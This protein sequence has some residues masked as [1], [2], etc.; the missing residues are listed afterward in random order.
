MP[1]QYV[2]GG[3]AQHQFDWETFDKQSVKI[4]AMTWDAVASDVHYP[5]IIPA[6]LA[7]AM[8]ER[9]WRVLEE[10]H[11]AMARQAYGPDHPA[12]NVAN[13]VR[14]KLDRSFFV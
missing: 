4:K 9:G 2:D 13:P 6:S 14:A 12:A 8:A 5:F 3:L 10:R 7:D 1:S 11:A